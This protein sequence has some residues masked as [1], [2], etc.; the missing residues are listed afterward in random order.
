MHRIDTSIIRLLRRQSERI[1]PGRLGPEVHQIV[2]LLIFRLDTVRLV[3]VLTTRNA[4]CQSHEIV[5]VSPQFG[6]VM[7][8]V[9]N[10]DDGSTRTL[11]WP[12]PFSNTAELFC[13]PSRS[14]S[15]RLRDMRI[16]R[17]FRLSQA[18]FARRLFGNR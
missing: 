17:F 10:T 12:I 1:E 13:F 18:N 3:V 4:A 8:G 6:T 15:T 14:L 11:V 9:A 2:L 7:A 5:D 16:A